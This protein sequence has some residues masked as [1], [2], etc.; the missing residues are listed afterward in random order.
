LGCSR[1]SSTCSSGGLTADLKKSP[2]NS[3]VLHGTAGSGRVNLQ[4]AVVQSP[5]FEAQ[6]TGTITLT[7][8]LTNSPIQIPVSVSLERL[9]A[10]RINMAGNTPPNLTYAKLPDFLSMKGTLGNPKTDINYVALAS[11]VMQGV[12][13]KTGQAGGALQ[14]LG[15]L[16]SG[17]TNTAS[18]SSTNQ[19][20]GKVGGLL[21]GIGGLL[22]N[23]APAA[24]NAPAT[25]QSPVN[26]LINGLFGPKKK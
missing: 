12:G 24:T 13:G 11:A 1:T 4:N 5:A 14:G 9:A 19:S 15:S 8:V 20:G 16:L 21:Q 10:Q 26:N 6:A 3:I 18:S 7:E 23:S 2:I 22:N 17:G 25:N